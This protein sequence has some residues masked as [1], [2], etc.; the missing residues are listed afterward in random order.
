MKYLLTV[1]LAILFVAELSAGDGKKQL[2]I[3]IKKKVENCPI[4]SKKGDAL[5]M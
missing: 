4:K 2:Q 3:G 1:T 5:S